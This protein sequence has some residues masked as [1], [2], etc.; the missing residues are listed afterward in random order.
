MREKFSDSRK[1]T[2]QV[3][4]DED[5]E[6]AIIKFLHPRGY[7]FLERTGGG[8]DVH[9]HIDRLDPAVVKTMEVGKAIRVYVIEGTKGPVADSVRPA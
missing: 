6:P 9:F 2:P 3:I 5:Y 1:K 8:K 4:P 7:G